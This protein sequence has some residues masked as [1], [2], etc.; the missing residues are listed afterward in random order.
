[1][2]IERASISR[3]E[4]LRWI[5]GVPAIAAGLAAS[6]AAAAEAKVSQKAAEYQNS[7]KG[8]QQCSGCQ[9]YIANAQ[10]P[11]ENG[12]CQVVEGSISPNDWCTLYAAK[13]T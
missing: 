3:R 2:N 10:D 13:G 11:K 8:N 9:N 7:P 1:M 4:T 5:A 12:S 6:L